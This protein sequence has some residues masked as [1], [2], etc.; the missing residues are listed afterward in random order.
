MKAHNMDN[1]NDMSRKPVPTHKWIITEFFLK[2]HQIKHAR[3]RILPLAFSIFFLWGSEFLGCL[4]RGDEIPIHNAKP[5]NEKQN[6][7]ENWE[8]GLR[9]YN[10]R[11]LFDMVSSEFQR[12]TPEFSYLKS[13][14]DQFLATSNY[15]SLKPG[16]DYRETILA[17]LETDL[18]LNTIPREKVIKSLD[19][20]L[21]T[22]LP[23]GE[24][25]LAEINQTSGETSKHG[26]PESKISFDLSSALQHNY[27]P[28]VSAIDRL[29][30]HS[31]HD[32]DGYLGFQTGP[33]LESFY[34]D[35]RLT[36]GFFMTDE[37]ETCSILKALGYPKL[38]RVNASGFNRR[39]RTIIGY[40]SLSDR[41][42]I[43]QFAFYSDEQLLNHQAR[44]YFLRRKLFQGAGE[45]VFVLRRRDP[46]FPQQ[47]EFKRFLK[48]L[49]E[50]VTCFF[51]GFT[52]QLK[53]ILGDFRL[54]NL[55]DLSLIVGHLP[56]KDAR[57]GKLVIGLS[58]F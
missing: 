12:E 10:Y 23:F 32:L 31:F 47:E 36:M 21:K 33:E 14:R 29:E 41:V 46:A 54:V 30:P 24:A 26:N 18:A 44:F 48:S 20:F 25:T 50:P 1:Q 37:P 3:I 13:K 28:E 35:K 58:G 27:S 49:N 42:C 51:A 22:Y 16:D 15:R 38:F 57:K 52:N 39:M 2:V 17:F 8:E 5:F 56:G 19:W 9:R 6:F 11:V 34:L 53:K 45:S 43:A 7:L 55:G 40:N 4:A